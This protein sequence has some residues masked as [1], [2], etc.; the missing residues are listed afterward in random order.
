MILKPGKRFLIGFLV[1]IFCINCSSDDNPSENIIVNESP[2]FN[3]SNSYIELE[4][5]YT[6]PTISS[7]YEILFVNSLASDKDQNLYILGQN[8]SEIKVFTKEGNYLETLGGPGRGPDELAY[9]VNMTSS[10]DKL[11]VIQGNSM[12]KILDFNGKY[13]EEIF[14]K[15]I[16]TA[17]FFLRNSNLFMIEYN[18]QEQ[19]LAN[20]E[21][22]S[23]RTFYLYKYSEDLKDKVDLFSTS[24]TA[25]GF[26]PS[27]VLTVDSK[28]NFYFPENTDSY[29]IVKYNVDGNKVFS[30]NREYKREPY[31]DEAKTFYNNKYRKSIE[32]GKRE[33]LS[34]NPPILRQFLVDSHDN[35]WVFSGEMS[36]ESNFAKTEN[37]I[38][39]FDS[40]GKWL[41]NFK[42]P[43]PSNSWYIF[44]DR[45]YTVTPVN[46]VNEQQHIH[47]YEIMYNTDR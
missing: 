20:N 31:S 19:T 2:G 29:S 25:P 4:R 46:E 3:S 18:S 45:L 33:K 28:G 17:D 30:F 11:F 21:K 5:I 1:V 15:R 26:M 35:L 23:I 8:E 40:K 27:T 37:T 13:I 10:R 12:M 44:N 9:P 16:N 6:I 36:H 39:I 7:N 34:G 24:E 47:A 43:D 41:Y 32:S 22:K 42:F 14:I 38:D